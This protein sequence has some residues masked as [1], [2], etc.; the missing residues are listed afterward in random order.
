MKNKEVLLLEAEV[1]VQVLVSAVV[2]K[3][4]FY[5]MYEVPVVQSVVVKDDTVCAKNTVFQTLAII[6]QKVSSLYCR[7]SRLYSENLILDITDEMILYFHSAVSFTDSWKHPALT[8]LVRSIIEYNIR[9]VA[10][11]TQVLEIRA[12]QLRHL[13]GEM[14]R[15]TPPEIAEAYWT[16]PN[17]LRYLCWTRLLSQKSAA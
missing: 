10:K 13:T 3:G 11:R 9:H 2:E 14:K 12:M 1:S 5:F 15:S 4:D 8:S 7:G 16:I 17:P 6:F